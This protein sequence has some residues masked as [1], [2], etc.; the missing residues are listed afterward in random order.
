M[1]RKLMSDGDW[2]L[3]EHFIT[4]IRAP[5]GRNPAG[6]RLVLDGVFWSEA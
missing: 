6:H 1:A 3:F 2:R 5:N 4:A